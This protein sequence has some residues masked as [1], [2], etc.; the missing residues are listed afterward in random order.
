M[1]AELFEKMGIFY[2][3]RDLEPKTLRPTKIPTLVKSKNFTTH[4]A[5][6]GMTGSGK[7]GLGVDILEEA[8]IDNIP[9]IVI[10]PKG[11][12]GDLCLTSE[13]LRAED[14][15]PWV[16]DEARQKGEEPL[17][18]ARKIAEMWREGIE[19]WGQSSDRIA[20]FKSHDATIYTPGSTAGVP[21]NVLGSLDAPDA[22]TLEDPDALAQSINAVVSSLLALLGIDAD[23]IQSREYILIAQILKRAWMA[24]EKVDIGTLISHIITLPFDKIGVLPLESFYPAA[25]RFKLASSMN[26]L[27]ASPSFESWL[28]G[29]PLDIDAL[30]YDERQKAKIS[31]FS[32][33]H[34]SDEERMFFVTLLLSRI[35]EWM[36]RQS[37]TGRLRALLYM[38]EIYG[39][40]PPSKNPPSKAPMMTLLKQARAF[41]VG[42]VLSTQNPVDLD[43]KG[44]GNIGTWFIGRL[45]TR[46]DIEKVIDG[47]AGKL[48]AEL[49]RDEIV[50]T[51]SNLPKRTFFYKSA[52]EKGIRLFQTRWVLSYLK[53]PLK[54]RDI[55]KLTA[56]KKKPRTASLS[57]ET[58]KSPAAQPNGKSRTPIL[59]SDIS[60]R[61]DL[62]LSPGGLYRPHLAA[63]AT[64]RYVNAA[65]GIDESESLA[66]CIPL[67]DTIDYPDWDEAE[68]CDKAF[69]QAPKKPTGDTAFAPLPGSVTQAK[70]FKAFQKALKDHLYTQK[71]LTLYR[72]RK[73]K[74]ESKPHESL[75]TFKNRLMEILEERL[76]AEKEKLQSR[77]AKKLQ[78]LHERLVRAQQK[79]AKEQE[80]VGKATTGS[81]V[82]AGLAIFGA[83]F[84][85]K[86]SAA[87]KL[88][89]AMKG[90]SRV[91]KERADVQRAQARIDE[92][93]T[94]IDALKEELEEKLDELEEKYRLERYEIETFFIKP[95]RTDVDVEMPILYW[96]WEPVA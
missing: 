49:D 92:I 89:Q 93:E 62:A 18:Y 39:Y 5:V 47:L 1:D 50:K 6:I 79:L 34:L 41:G 61:F 87:S 48:D 10:D 27:I 73:L 40:F 68:P 69:T 9:V 60:Q 91:L 82:D 11:D 88:G 31:I 86:R 15:L 33:A 17:E 72:C 85:G 83:L 64:V 55:A 94:Q 7:T 43:Y 80:D 3:G 78:T 90:G 65:R 53:G 8:A 66:L 58:P 32:I 71:R 21:V 20:R 25:E 28:T 29:A 74:A 4:A 24:G 38:D 54:K 67:D 30:M 57:H 77:Y 46:Q 26:N 16:E 84:G 35:V 23:P 45:Q 76:D 52:H 95:R 12:M 36:R 51:L 14:F 81:L 96:R 2:L 19:S 44:L 56:A 70:N 75:E 42:V 22:A 13:K 59:S 37:G 63:A